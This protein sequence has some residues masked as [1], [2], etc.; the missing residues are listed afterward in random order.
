MNVVQ[1][2]PRIVRFGETHD[3][4]GSSCPH[5]GA[6]GRWIYTFTLDNGR[7]AGAMRGCLSLFPVSRVAREELRLREKLAKYQKSYGVSATLNRRDSEAL[8]AIE[9]FYAGACDERSA[10]SVVDRAKKANTARYRP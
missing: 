6:D 3:S 2:L 5:C 8:D 4:P 1:S 7:T 9:A 10:L